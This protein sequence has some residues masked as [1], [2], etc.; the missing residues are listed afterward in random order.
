MAVEAHS[1]VESF[2]DLHVWEVSSGFPALSAHVL[3]PP[4]DDCHAVRRE[5]EQAGV[6]ILMT[7]LTTSPTSSLRT[8]ER[9]HGGSNFA[10]IPVEE[11]TYVEVNLAARHFV[12]VK[13]FS[14]IPVPGYKPGTGK[15]LRTCPSTNPDRWNRQLVLS[16]AA[17]ELVVVDPKDGRGVV[18]R[19]ERR[20][21]DHR[22]RA[23]IRGLG[24]IIP[25]L[26]E[27]GAVRLARPV[28]LRAAV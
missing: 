23:L 4:G 18:R 9:P 11:G 12:E 10:K 3:V 1:H 15:V 27:H 17:G 19:N 14:V 20:V 25:A 7:A 2:H 8:T 21:G 22:S 24:R 28:R 5:L 26:D 13:N 16:R 6:D